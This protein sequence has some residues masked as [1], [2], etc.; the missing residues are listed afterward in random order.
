MPVPMYC[1][2]KILCRNYLSLRSV[3]I[4]YLWI[5]INSVMSIKL[6]NIG[7]RLGFSVIDPGVLTE[8]LVFI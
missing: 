7:L 4:G 2:L 8:L 6:Q 3:I 1:S 5:S